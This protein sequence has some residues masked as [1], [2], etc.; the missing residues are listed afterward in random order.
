MPCVLWFTAN[1]FAR[2]TIDRPVY[3]AHSHRVQQT[4]R[5]VRQNQVILV[6]GPNIVTATRQESEWQ[7]LLHIFR[8]L[9]IFIFPARWAIISMA[10]S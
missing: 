8:S 2:M 6:L 5:L 1:R 7:V 3:S 4:K 9:R 10:L